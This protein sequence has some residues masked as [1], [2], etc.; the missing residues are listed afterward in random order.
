[1]ATLVHCLRP[2]SEPQPA[3]WQAPV[4]QGIEHRPPEAGARVRISPGAQGEKPCLQGKRAKV[5]NRDFGPL[6]IWLHIS[7]ATGL[8]SAALSAP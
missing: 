4:A 5:S 6:H 2:S 7:A 8:R 3:E 1:M